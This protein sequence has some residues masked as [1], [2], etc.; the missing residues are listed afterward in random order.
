MILFLNGCSSSGKSTLA[1]ALQYS[2]E[3]ASLTLGVDT[4]LRMMPPHYKGFEEKAKE[5]VFFTSI[6]DDNGSR[7]KIESGPFG[8]KLFETAPKIIKLLGLEGFDLIIDEVLLGKEN[9][10]HYVSQL[11]E[12]T[13]YFIGVMCDLNVMEEREILRG[14]R[15]LGLARGQIDDVQFLSPFYDLVVD[16]TR[17]SSFECAQEILDY[18]RKNAHP[19]GFNQLEATF[20]YNRG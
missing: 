20:K 13:V 9:I 2:L 18:V 19:T 8:K 14:N 12:F 15:I 17:V 16:T 6:S 7:I 11:K 10:K 5:G 3:G 4:F 1:R